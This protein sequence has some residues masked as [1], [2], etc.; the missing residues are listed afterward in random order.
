MC[1]YIGN[2]KGHI[3]V[4]DIVCFKELILKDGKYETPYQET[5]VTLGKYL[6]PDSDPEISEYGFKY[7]MDGGVIHAYLDLS[8]CVPGDTIFKAIIKK[9]TRFWLQDDLREV[10]AEKLFIT[11]EKVTYQEKFNYKSLIPYA[12]KIKTKDGYKVSLE[13]VSDYKDV[14]G[15][16]TSRSLVSL[17]LQQHNKPL[18]ETKSYKFYDNLEKALKDYDGYGNTKDLDVKHLGDYEYIPSLGELTEALMEMAEMNIVRKILGKEQ[19]IHGWF[20]SSTMKERE[21]AW[22]CYGLGYFDWVFSRYV[23]SRSCVL[24]FL[25]LS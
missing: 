1:L 25:E 19:I 12:S 8:N 22:R 21:C 9:G 24:P 3:A 6:I 13:D 11:E 16:Y 2:K 17:N 5:K 14:L 18:S 15:V 7:K 4:N 20:W 23:H 10:A